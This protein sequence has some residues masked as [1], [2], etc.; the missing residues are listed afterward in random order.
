MHGLAS[1]ALIAAFL[2][3]GCGPL[4]PRT[5]VAP[6]TATGA[7][8]AAVLR[9]AAR[10]W[11]GKTVK[12][13]MLSGEMVSGKVRAAS[14]AGVGIFQ[15]GKTHDN[16]GNKLPEAVPDRVVELPYESMQSIKRP[17]SVGSWLLIGAALF[18]TWPLIAYG[19]YPD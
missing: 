5:T 10:K 14:D 2:C 3:N 17:A 9:E 7:E 11:L 15:R 19:G 1:C 13:T 6:P 16:F 12:V 18:V 8:R 4:L